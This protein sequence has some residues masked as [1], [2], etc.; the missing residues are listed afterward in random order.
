M[1]QR[2]RGSEATWKFCCA[3]IAI[4]ALPFLLEATTGCGFQAGQLS[5][6][7]PNSYVCAC[8]CEPGQHPQDVRVSAAFDDAE[9]G[10]TDAGDLDLGQSVVGVRFTGLNIPPGAAVLSAAVQFTA[11]QAFGGDNTGPINLDVYGVAADDAPSFGGN[12]VNV[13]AMDR[14]IAS[15]GWPIPACR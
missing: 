14:T 13:A 8:D 11:D 1:I 7:Y 9:G 10:T 12:F 5:P 15:I 6:V 3:L 2:K 4:L